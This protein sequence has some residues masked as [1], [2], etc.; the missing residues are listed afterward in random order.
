MKKSTAYLILSFAVLPFMIAT[1]MVDNSDT[2]LNESIPTVEELYFTNKPLTLTEQE[3]ASLEIVEKWQQSKNSKPFT[4][5]DGSVTFLYGVG[6]PSIVCAPLQVCDIAL[7]PGEM[8]TSMH[9]GDER[10]FAE[11]AVT[12]QGINAIEHV[13]IK[14]KDSGLETNLIITTDLRTYNLLLRSDRT[15]YMPKV[16]FK[17]PQ[18]ELA[19]FNARRAKEATMRQEQTLPETNEY[20]GDLNFDY[21]ISGEAAWKPLRVYNNGEKT[22]LQMPKDM[23]KTE[24]PTL[25]V[26]RGGQGWFSKDEQVMVNYRVQGDRFIVDTVFDEAILI[27]GIGRNQQRVTIVRKQ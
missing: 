24:A 7:Q 1:A 10:W 25:L 26:I 2:V 4:G 13:I 8:V 23:K 14:I 9:L 17:Y 16:S 11:S 5:K 18:D 3:K 6:Q 21:D 22:I 15:L 27:T 19:E 12:G 20:L